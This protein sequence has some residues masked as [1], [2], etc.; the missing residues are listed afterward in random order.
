[1]IRTPKKLDEGANLMVEQAKTRVDKNHS[2]LVGRFYNI[3]VAVRPTR[4][5]N[6]LD[7][8]LEFHGLKN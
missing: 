5:C 2:M 6:V 7:A 1:V 8:E 3:L 4:A